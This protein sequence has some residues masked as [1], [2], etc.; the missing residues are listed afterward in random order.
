MLIDIGS[1]EVKSKVKN[2]PY[3]S[4]SVEIR[5]ELLAYVKHYKTEVSGCGL[6]EAIEHREKNSDKDKPDIITTEYKIVEIYLPS[7]QDNSGAST[8]I[9]PEE[10]HSLMHTLL[11]EN[12][13]PNML[14]LHWHSHADFSVFHSGTDE[15]NYETLNNSDWLVSLVINHAEEFLGRVDYY[16]PI[17]CTITGIPVYMDIPV[18]S[19]VNEKVKANILALDKHV[20]EKKPAYDYREK[21]R[22]A[23][24]QYKNNT[25]ESKDTLSWWEEEKIQE[26]QEKNRIARELKIGRKLQEHFEN[27]IDTEKCGRCKHEKLCTEYNI[28]ISQIGEGSNYGYSG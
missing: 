19:E 5:N 20:E 18:S 3:I 22:T 23:I 27:C 17:E 10:I 13:D 11:T 7:K 26:E 25:S 4:M 21:W 1:G 12:K 16:K 28:Q 14:R 9:E 8:D 24:E 2:T 6:I 15:D